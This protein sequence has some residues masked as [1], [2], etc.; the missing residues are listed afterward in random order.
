MS[1]IETPP[2]ATD[3][4]RITRE[5]ATSSRVEEMVARQR[6]QR[7]EHDV[8]DDRGRRWWYQ[9][10][11]VLGIVGLLG[12]LVAVLLTE[13]FYE[14]NP[15][16]QGKIEAVDFDERIPPELLRVLPQRWADSVDT[17]WIRVGG[18]R[19]F[20]MDSTRG[21]H[22]GKLV[23]LHAA[24]LTVG[25]GVRVLTEYVDSR[26]E[27][28]AL[29]F[30][31]DTNPA[32]LAPGAAKKL[33][34]VASRSEGISFFLFSIVS[35]VVGFFLGAAD[36]V[37]CRLP[38]R[39]ILG[40]LVG[41]L[42]GGVG[43]LLLSVIGNIFYSPVSEAASRMMGS[44][45]GT[46]QAAGL[47]FQMGA[48]AV[49]WALIGVSTGLGQG[50]ALRSQRLL[51]FGAIGGAVGG[52]LGG[53]LFD[54]ID[55][56]ISGSHGD[57]AA[58]RTV[59]LLAIGASVGLLIGVVELIGRDAWL[60]MVEGPLAGK[61]FVLFRDVMTIGAAPTSDIYLWGDPRVHAK[62]ATIRGIGEECEIEAGDPLHPVTVNGLA[63]RRARL[64]PG[65][66]IGVGR[67]L[68]LFERRKP[69]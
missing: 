64:R 56:M 10:W 16:T 50:I 25:R 57:A 41:A 3:V 37:I 47:L 63:V 6:S 46:L 66:R 12:A 32:K 21:L 17:G 59:G 49:A 2:P 18:V 58:S 60:R 36:G 19:I 1:E 8:V 52:A 54:P 15:S 51:I 13:P 35:A 69:S 14:D 55:M 26:A 45:S 33:A 34:D 39:A 62:H 24:E 31:I 23:P 28:F 40:A 65:D 68:L 38:R 67:A 7:G 29:A 4:L 22:D 5:E 20:F 30:Y 44:S 43:G 27:P 61:E 53:L 48:R 42:V 9:S 11:F